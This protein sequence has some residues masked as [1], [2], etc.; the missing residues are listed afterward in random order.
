MALILVK[1]NIF[2]V[3]DRFERAFKLKKLFKI[4]EGHQRKLAHTVHYVGYQRKWINTGTLLIRVRTHALY[5]ERPKILVL[6]L[7]E[8]TMTTIYRYSQ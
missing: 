2:A 8:S 4:V 7:T 1:I 6:V 3:S 5:I